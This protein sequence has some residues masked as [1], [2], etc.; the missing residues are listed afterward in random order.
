MSAKLL[1]RSELSPQ[2][3]RIYHQIVTRVKG[4]LWADYLAGHVEET[5]NFVPQY[6]RFDILDREYSLRHYACVQCRHEIHDLEVSECTFHYSNGDP[7]LY[8]CSKCQVEN[9][10][11]SALEEDPEVKD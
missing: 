6:L 2:V 1:Q 8:V 7:A 5:F 4:S 10:L 3:R 9:F 11:T